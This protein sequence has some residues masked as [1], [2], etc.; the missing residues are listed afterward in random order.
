M[1]L[2]IFI[3]LLTIIISAI[4]FRQIIIIE[5]GVKSYSDSFLIDIITDG[6]GS[7][8]LFLTVMFIPILNIVLTLIDFILISS[9]DLSNEDIEKKIKKILFIKDKEKKNVDS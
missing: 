4:I 5:G 3:W 9:M 7:I 6:D 2:F 8:L 1:I